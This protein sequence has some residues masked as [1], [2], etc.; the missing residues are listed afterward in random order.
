M[1]LRILNLPDYKRVRVEENDRDY[2]ITAEI[3]N[4]PT[5]CMACGSERLMT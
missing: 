3:S 1:T 4:A 2:H 5:V